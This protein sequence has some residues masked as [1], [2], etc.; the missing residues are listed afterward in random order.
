[1]LDGLRRSLRRERNKWEMVFVDSG[2]AAMAEM[3]LAPFDLVV[4][5]MRMPGMGGHDLLSRVRD[6][7]PDTVRIVLSGQTDSEVAAR[8]VAVSHQFL[9]KPCKGEQL[10][11]ILQRACAVRE[12]IQNERVRRS[13]SQLGS[14]PSAP[15]VY[16]KLTAALADPEISAKEVGQIVEQDMGLA[17]K[18]LQVVNSAYFGLPREMSHIHE[19]VSFLGIKLIQVLTLAEET[20]APFEG[21]P[22]F[23]AR[24]L[25]VEQEHGLL[26]ASVAR[27][28]SEDER[29]AERAFLAGMLHDLGV[30]LLATERPHET[31]R[32]ADGYLSELPWWEREREVLGVHHGQVGAFLLGTWGLPIPVTEAVAFHHEPETIAHKGFDV[33]TA[34]H[35][36]SGLVTELKPRSNPCEVAAELDLGYLERL[37]VAEHLPGWRETALGIVEA[38][39]GQS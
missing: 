30:V 16:L 34:V 14:L 32:V 35:V 1:M 26:T 10:R 23:S 37:G 38:S 6:D 5:D 36:A 3:E 2:D 19:A 17:A 22:F 15:E 31:K 28:I 18:I 9:A 24:D 29:I 13:I 21:S 12:L 11:E 7:F 8:S 27:A 33:V 20:F 39:D 4:S 25:R